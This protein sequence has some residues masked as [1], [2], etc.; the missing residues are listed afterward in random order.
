MHGSFAAAIWDARQEQL[1]LISDCFGTRPLY[2]TELD[3]SVLFSSS[4][5]ALMTD[6]RVSRR[7]DTKGMSQFF[8]FGH[9]LRDNTSIEAV[10]VLPAGAVMSWSFKTGERRVTHHTYRSV[11]KNVSSPDRFTREEWLDQIDEAFL[12]AIQRRTKGSEQLGLALSGGMDAR[13]ILAVLDHSRLAVKTVC[14]GVK[15]SVDH[16]S[17]QK[18]ADLVGCQHH[19]HE[20][21]SG[22]LS[23]FGRHLEDMV[24]LTDGQYLSQCIVM[25]T[26]PIYRDLGIDVLMRGHAG[27]LMHMQKAYNY[28]VGPQVAAIRNERDLEE[29]LFRSL[30]AYMLGGIDYQVL[31]LPHDEMVSLARESLRQDLQDISSADPPMQTVSKLFITQRLRRET[32]LSLMKFRSEVEVRVPY[33]DHELVDLLLSSPPELRLGEHIQAHILRRRF[34]EFLSVTNANTGTRIGA[35]RLARQVSTFR[36]RVLRKL[37][38]PG[39]Q[40][41]EKLGL[42]L[43]RELAETVRGILLSP[44]CLERGV[45]SPDGVKAVVQGHLSGKRNHT[46]LLLALVVSEQGQ[47]WLLD[48]EA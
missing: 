15:G 33:L 22:F 17:S 40:P 48:E 13:S 20:L 2:Y 38:V 9:Y 21:N 12:R 23:T 6:A 34:P 47:R 37:G 8:S 30:Q 41:Y 28:S 3:D 10:R 35:G 45:F 29:Y 44:R 4:I 46:A 32:S 39:Y 1:T 27:E 7:P 26:L 25:P 42:W 31:A 11:E 14:L 5:K 16:C 18:M 43:R 36:L 24:R 19:N